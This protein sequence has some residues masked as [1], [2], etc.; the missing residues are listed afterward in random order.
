MGQKVTGLDDVSQT[1]LSDRV[2][3]FLTTNQHIKR[4]FSALNV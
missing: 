3:S 4:P 2:S 1:C